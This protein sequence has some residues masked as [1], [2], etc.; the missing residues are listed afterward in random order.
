MKIDFF[1]IFRCENFN[2]WLECLKAE[3]G[4]L[5]WYMKVVVYLC[6]F[7][8]LLLQSGLIEQINLSVFFYICL[9]LLIF[10][11]YR[12]LE[13]LFWFE[14]HHLIYLIFNLDSFRKV[15]CFRNLVLSDLSRLPYPFGYQARVVRVSFFSH[16]Y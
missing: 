4:R 11:C 5:A 14:P 9:C 13:I 15:S 7:L 2:I 12:Y 10:S 3:F 6:K 16:D 1:L 8:I